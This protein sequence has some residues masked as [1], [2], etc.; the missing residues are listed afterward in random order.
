M[1]MLRFKMDAKLG[2]IK[3]RHKLFLVFATLFVLY[4]LVILG[5]LEVVIRHYDANL[6]AEAKGQLNVGSSI[7][8]RELER[9]GDLSFEIMTDDS[10]QETLQQMLDNPSSYATY[11][12]KGNLYKRI[13]SYFQD[14]HFLDYIDLVSR[15]GVHFT[16]G[17][18]GQIQSLSTVEQAQARKARGAHV[19]ETTGGSQPTLLSV[20]DVRSEASLGQE[21]LGM[22]Q[23]K[24][25]LDGLVRTY[26]DLSAGQGLL[27]Y[28]DGKLVYASDP[29]LQAIAVNLPSRIRTYGILRVAG[30]RDFVARMRDGEFDYFS[31]IPYNALFDDIWKL[32]LGCFAADVALALGTLLI[33]CRLSG[34]VSRP[35][36]QLTERMKEVQAGNMSPQHV[37]PDGVASDEI[38]ELYTNFDLMMQRIND[39]IEENYV[40]EL[41]VK[42]A[43]FQALQ[44]QINPH[45]LYNTLN[46]INWLA[47]M[48]HQDTI[49][50]MVEA[51]ASL[52]RQMTDRHD[53]LVS[54]ADELTIV[55][56]YLTIQKVRFGDRLHCEIA[57]DDAL[58]A[59]QIPKLTIQPLV[60]NAIK[61][62]LEKVEGQ[63]SI[64]I[65]AVEC[66]SDLLVMVVD[67]GPGADETV[68]AQSLSGVGE[69]T[70]NKIGLRNIDRRIQAV[71][72]E[73]YGLSVESV[74][75]QGTTVILR[76]AKV[77]G[78]YV[79]GFAL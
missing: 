77:G 21:E 79:Q 36:E 30:H 74:R 69:A 15:D 39:L 41:L 40:K 44:A 61:H 48:N 19:W 62:G 73:D 66:D 56:N 32:R 6:Y 12:S 50:R 55:G 64:R 9:I 58:K 45:F 37:T 4:N 71:F 67:D 52:L 53:T 46:S 75:G 25:N 31:F 47:R 23:M 43:E 22:L 2:T 42:E 20:R 34:R 16:A 26:L 5:L 65:R 70:S 17:N 14:S 63:L 33:I 54:L 38:G 51:L 68:F 8:N 59:C 28:K 78:E 10:V 18:N 57:I 7:I 49:S 13:T 11:V 35:L 76:M 27:M 29:D 3:I 24:V 72:G 60:E 1:G